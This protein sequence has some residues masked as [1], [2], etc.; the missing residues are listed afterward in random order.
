MTKVEYFNA[1]LAIPEVAE[2]EEYVAFLNKEIDL[3]KAKSSKAN[4][5]K[6]KETAGRVEAV[7]NELVRIGKPITVKDFLGET[8]LDT[9]EFSKERVTALLRKLV[10]ANRVTATKDKKVT[11]YAVAE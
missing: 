5:K 1:I 4:E 6:E 8:T 2:N 10:L 11:I 9:T 7:Y 3:L